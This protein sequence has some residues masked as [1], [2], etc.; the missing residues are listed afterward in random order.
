[1]YN[2]VNLPVL[3]G[4]IKSVACSAIAGQTELSVI[5]DVEHENHCKQLLKVSINS[6]L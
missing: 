3:W 4:V 2:D 5:G 6:I 1:M